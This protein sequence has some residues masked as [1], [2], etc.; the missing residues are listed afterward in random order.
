MKLILGVWLLLAAFASAETL[1]IHLMSRRDQQHQYYHQLVLQ[2]L[3]AQGHQVRVIPEPDMPLVRIY[4]QLENGGLSGHWLLQTAERDRQ[5]LRV[6]IPLTFGLIGQRVLLVKKGESAAYAHIH[7]LRDL[8]LS[9][10][11]AGMAQGW[12]DVAIWKENHLPVYEQSGDWQVLYKLIGAKDRG[13]DYLPRGAIEAA[14][15]IAQ[16]PDL[17]IE[18]HL[19]LSY[20]RDFVFY[21][22]PHYPKLRDQIEQALQAAQASGLQRRLFNQWL[23]SEV[24]TLNLNQ[25]SVIYLNSSRKD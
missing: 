21:I 6:N 11:R 1:D 18:P 13:V 23:E 16:Y 15:E 3:Q 17:E 24:K 20:E 4:K 8:Q 12:L 5:F 14:V 10:K 19:L 22:S 2:S 9:N 7:N 25:R